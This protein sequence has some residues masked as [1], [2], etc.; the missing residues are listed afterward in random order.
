MGMGIVVVWSN[1]WVVALPFLISASCAGIITIFLWKSSWR[2]IQHH[3]A[4]CVTCDS[5]GNL[6][7]AGTCQEAYALEYVPGLLLLLFF[8]ATFAILTLFFPQII[9]NFVLPFEAAP[10]AFTFYYAVIIAGTVAGTALLAGYLVQELST[11]RTIFLRA[12]A[13]GTLGAVV[14]SPIEPVAAGL[15]PIGLLLLLLGV[16]IELR[17]RTGRPLLGLRSL[18]LAVLPLFVLT[19]L[20]LLRIF[21][22]VTIA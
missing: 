19:L 4:A 15:V 22:L 18:G 2:G 17:A 10:N 20:G 3:R 11:D 5:E 13:L 8:M 9:L 1:L 16:G 6:E 7:A 21:E 14:V 12:T